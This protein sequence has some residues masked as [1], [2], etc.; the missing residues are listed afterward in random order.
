MHKVRVIM[1][2]STSKSPLFHL[3]TPQLLKVSSPLVIYDS[4]ANIPDR[5]NLIKNFTLLREDFDNDAIPQWAFITPNM[6]EY[7]SLIIP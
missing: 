5:V 1:S 2:A 7:Q 3:L 4:V 6:S